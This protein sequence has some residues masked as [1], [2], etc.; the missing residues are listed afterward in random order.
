MTTN[1]NTVGGAF[2]PKKRYLISVSH[3]TYGHDD[4]AYG[5]MLVANGILAKGL[6]VT[7]LL[8]E[9]GVYMAVKGQDPN[10]IGQENNLKQ[11]ADFLDLGGQ[12]IVLG[13]STDARALDK[14]ELIDGIM[15]IGNKDLV[16]VLEEH[17][18]CITF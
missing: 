1:I 15:I 16:K 8:R 2:R 14:D 12:L 11:L 3:G 10:E 7:L 4:D 9:D 5:A 13:P 17:D 18:F 6:D